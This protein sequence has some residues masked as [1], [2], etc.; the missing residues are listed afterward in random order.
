MRK[1]GHRERAAERASGAGSPH[2]FKAKSFG[3]SL[4]F[5]WQGL[6]RVFQTERNF[7]THVVMVGLVTV[8]G[9]YLQVSMLAWGLL[10]LSMTL[11]L[12]TEILNTALEYL[13][14]MLAEGRYDAQAKAIKD[15]A[16]GA[17]L[18]CA[19]GVALVGALV[20][21]PALVN[22]LGSGGL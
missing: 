11:M 2:P 14:D 3:H 4:G 19:L 13:V 6:R 20:F 17:C 15:I 5:A 12:V 8:S 10:I 18:V 16:A 7:Q 21:V 1:T 22:R 9:L